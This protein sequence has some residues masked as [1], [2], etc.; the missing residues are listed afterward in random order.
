VAKSEKTKEAV[1]SGNS[2]ASIRFA[3]LCHLLDALGF[4]RRHGK[5]SHM[6]FT[7]IGVIEIINLQ[8]GKNGKAKPYQVKQVRLI[9]NNYSL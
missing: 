5:G 8:P 2:A 1:L 6:I 4:K 9:I 7:R 3:D